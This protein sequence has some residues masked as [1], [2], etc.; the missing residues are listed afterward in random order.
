MANKV[1]IANVLLT[2]LC[3]LDCSYCAIV[4]DYEGMP[5][6]YPKM[7]YYHKNQLKAEQWI[8]I[9]SR[10]VENNPD[11]FF[12]L[13]GGEPT[14][15]KDLWKIIKWMNENDV[16]YTVITN[17]HKIAVKRIYQI[18]DRVGPLRGLTSSCDPVFLVPD[19]P[20]DDIA[21]KSKEGLENLATMKADGIADDVVA[22]ITIMKESMPYLIPLIKTLSEKNIYSSITAVDDQKSPFYDFSNVGSEVL[23]PKDE[24]IRGIF[25]EIIEGSEKGELLVH[26]PGLLNKLY[27]YLPSTMRCTLNRDLHNVS[28]EPNGA[29]RLC[30]RVKG[31]AA[32]TINNL[33]DIISKDGVFTSKLL[34][35]IK[36]DYKHYC[37]GCNW[38]C[39]IMSG[40]FKEQIIDHC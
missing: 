11:V 23:L 13:Y 26:I 32:T 31:V 19:R 15:V 10:L 14:L 1:W 4:K 33:D 16:K 40:D 7:K 37:K 22:E 17:N 30:L 38:T 27:E 9:F 21:I 34:D 12:I 29:F 39:P 8:E 18:Y 28:I 24:N 36:Y 3:N 2:R 25:D 35:A 5:E 6:E 20:V